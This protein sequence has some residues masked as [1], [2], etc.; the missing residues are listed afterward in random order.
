MNFPWGHK[1][2]FNSYAQHCKL[3]YG[4]RLQKLSIH[5]GFTC[6]NRDGKLG[7]GGCSFCSNEGFN[8]SYCSPEKT[9]TQQI[10]EGIDFHRTR[11]HRAVKYLAYFQPYSNTYAPIEKLRAVYGEAL[12]HPGISGI[13]IG[14]RPDCMSPEILDY[15]EKL[16]QEHFISIEYGI[17]SCYNR[18]LQKVNRGHSFEQSVDAIQQTAERGIQCG[19]HLIFGLPGESRQD[20]L[21][22]AAMISSLPL[23]S[24]KLHQLQIL[25]GTVMAEEYK[26][27][28][29]LFQLFSLEEYIGFII[30]FL[31][32]LRS[33]LLIERLTAEVPPR[34]L[35]VPGWGLIRNDQVMVKIETRMEERNTWQGKMTETE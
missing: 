4:T 19:A 33:G 17:E 11:Y 25:K 14:T 34:F 15:L 26:K 5:A 10:N 16:S 6:P 30:D 22:E 3:K 35:A 27:D 13:S 20:M 31:E 23:D 32:L 29:G 7:K 24:I 21:A 2:R 18:T 8:P 1:R 28:P 12:S 9:V